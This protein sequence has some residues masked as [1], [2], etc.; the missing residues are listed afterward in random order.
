MAN[1]RQEGAGSG[2]EPEEERAPSSQAIG[3][4]E[5][6][7][8]PAERPRPV[9]IPATPRQ[10]ADRQEV[11]AIWPSRAREGAIERGERIDPE[12]RSGS[13]ESDRR[14]AEAPGKPSVS[15]S[16]APSDSW[17]LPASVRDRFV[18]V[19]HRYY[20][21]DGA[22]A[23]RDH[24]RRLT[25]GSE[26]TEVIATLIDIARTRGWDEIT[27]QGTEQFRREVWRQGLEK[28]LEVRGYRASEPERAALVRSLAR[29]GQRAQMELDVA[30]AGAERNEGA[31]AVPSETATTREVA[32]ARGPGGVQSA[33]LVGKLIDHGSEAYRF[34]PK[35]PMS[36]FVEVETRKGKRTI[37][38][39]DLER[40]IKESLSKPKIGDE[41]AM[42][43]T[44]ADRVTVQRK[45]R[46]G[47]GKV[48]AEREVGTQRNRWVL[49]KREFFESRAAAAEVLRNPAVD[50]R[51]AVRQHP[52][53]VG[54]YLQLRAAELASK[55]IR[56]P[57]DQKKFVA[58]VRQA[59]ADS[60]ARGEPLQ[61]VRLRDRPQRVPERKA[62][63][64]EQ[65][66]VRA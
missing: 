58:L 33:L 2:G 4:T 10:I 21:K 3:R 35:E 59:L 6:R 42:R 12:S 13:A 44:G 25:T 1:E 26:N 55:R 53:L 40:A 45:E 48:I 22:P 23:F 57:E 43:R 19:K 64:R 36:Y 30:E 38:G 28:G 34:D 39:K 52:E 60:I 37:W 54:T 5:V 41:I 9:F 50:G 49:E 20:F 15:S 66:P 24:G 8:A 46:D 18:E 17:A 51:Q 11:N 65:G 62:R 61:P 32:T 16:A 14:R 7:P 27:V 63:E 47:E 31:A 29:R 56:D